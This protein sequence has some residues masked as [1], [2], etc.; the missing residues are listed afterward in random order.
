MSFLSQI[1]I[2]LLTFLLVEFVL[3]TFALGF[4]VVWRILFY[5]GV[6]LFWQV[7]FGMSGR[8]HGRRGR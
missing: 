1:G 6:W 4:T 3:S 5:A 7:V 8:S 2:G